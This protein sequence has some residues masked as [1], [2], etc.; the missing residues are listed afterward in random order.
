MTPPASA[1][2]L[3]WR[4]I[5]VAAACAGAL[6]LT[7]GGCGSGD[8]DEGTNGM[9]DLPATE[10]EEQARQAAVDASAVRLS[11]TVISEGQ[12]YRLDVRLSEEGAVGE[13]SAEG[14]TFELL[15]VGEDLYI[16]ADEAFWES[17]GIPEELESDPAEKLDGKYVRVAPEDPAYGQLTGFT[18]K[19]TLLEGLLTL[20][21][22]RE[23]GER[24]EVEGVRTIRVEAD[25]GEGG[26]MDVSLDG[27]PYPMRLERGGAAGELMM[28]DWGEAFALRAPEED[29]IVDY[30]DDIITPGD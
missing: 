23:T 13:V 30:G 1:S 24:G 2:L 5:P 18:D 15:R 20:D 17:E 11:G 25:G 22:E 26:A 19:E 14:A 7:L 27:A 8:P 10:I 9:G 6:A 3:R 12:S 28:D 4:R 21:G 29:D 16:K